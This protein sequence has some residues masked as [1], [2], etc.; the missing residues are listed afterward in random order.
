MSATEAPRTKV[1]SNP[2]RC[3]PL[4]ASPEEE[5]QRSGQHLPPSTPETST[6]LTRVHFLLKNS[7]PA[8]VAQR[9]SF[10]L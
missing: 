5:V 3:F 6:D 4:L 10:D 7:E 1:L 8:S 2:Q 9:L